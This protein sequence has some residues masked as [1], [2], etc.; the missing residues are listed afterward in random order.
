[1]GSATYILENVDPPLLPIDWSVYL[2]QLYMVSPNPPLQSPLAVSLDE[3]SIDFFFFFRNVIEYH[4]LIILKIEN[5]V[6]SA[7][8]KVL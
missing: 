2:Y 1:M 5:L 6:T 4:V 3:F 8:T 7:L